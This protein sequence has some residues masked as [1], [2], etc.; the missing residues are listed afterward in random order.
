M[1]NSDIAC[2]SDHLIQNISENLGT[3]RTKCEMKDI[4]EQ[5]S[6]DDT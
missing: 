4:V 6:V 1:E 3:L 2:G 5:N